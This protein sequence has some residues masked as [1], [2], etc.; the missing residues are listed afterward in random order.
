M[1]ANTFII[2]LYPYLKGFESTEVS[3][4]EATRMG[5]GS[6]PFPSYSEVLLQIDLHG[7]KS[8]HISDKLS[9]L[10]GKPFISYESFLED[11]EHK[12]KELKELTR[13]EPTETNYTAHLNIRQ[14]DANKNCCWRV[15]RKRGTR[16]ET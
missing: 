4:I 9:R 6:A 3:H 16:E 2:W 14:N 7:S 12:K 11:Q 10:H 15:V 5:S 1:H 13:A 8:T